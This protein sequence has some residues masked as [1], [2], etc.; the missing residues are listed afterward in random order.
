[1]N[2]RMK[3][4][5]GTMLKALSAT[6]QDALVE[7]WE[8]DFRAFGG[9]VF[10]FCNQVNEMNQAVVWKGQEYTPYPISAEGFEMTSQGAGNRPTLTVS[11]LLGFVTGAAVGVVR[12]LTY[13]RFLDAANFKAGNPTADPNQEIIGKYV[14]EQMTSLTAERAVFELAAPSESDG[15]I[16]PSRMMLANTCIW[17]YRG[18]GCGY[19]G[20]PVADRY[21][22]P[23]DDPKKDVCSGTLTGCRA[24]FGATAVLPFGGFPSAD[25]VMS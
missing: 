11:N 4:M 17:Q 6:Q 10:R 3:A 19:T 8:V 24:R 13:A 15:A 7:M 12:R 5:S 21:D 1:M 2:A 14:I 16:I 9:E 25:K 23:T 20:R 18:E 22:I